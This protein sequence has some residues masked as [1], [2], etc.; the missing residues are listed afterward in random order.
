VPVAG[1]EHELAA[2]LIVTA[3]GQRPDLSVLDLDLAV[4]GDGSVEV[5]PTTGA[6]SA[7]GV[8]AGGD[9][10]AGPKTV[11]HAIADGR[12]AAYGI[13]LFLAGEGAMVKPVDFVDLQSLTFFS[14]R[15]LAPEPAH[16]VQLRPAEERRQDHEDVVVPLDEREAREE[17]AR[18][19]LCAM[20]RSCSACTDLFGCPALVEDN[21]RMVIDQALCSGCGVCVSFCPNGAIHEVVES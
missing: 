20:C 10:T 8:F 21:G 1:S 9:L 13:D 11:I 2:D 17:A 4:S 3:V 5:D 7:R 19:L 16:R 12:R 14:P 15:N 6:T 18:C